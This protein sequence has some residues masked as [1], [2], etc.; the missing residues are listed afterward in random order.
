[1]NVPGGKLETRQFNL[2]RIKNDAAAVGAEAA[3]VLLRQGIYRS[4]C[5]CANSV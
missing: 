1:M 5:Q 3:H 4:F 2:A